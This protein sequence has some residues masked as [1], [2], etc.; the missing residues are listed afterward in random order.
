MFQTESLWF[1]PLFLY[2]ETH[3]RFPYFFS[4]LRKN[5]PE[6]IADAPHRIEPGSPLPILILIKDAHLS[7]WSK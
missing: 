7:N 4:L 6:I 1:L 2:A 3:Y 5:E